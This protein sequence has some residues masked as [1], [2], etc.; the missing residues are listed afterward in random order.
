[1]SKKITDQRAYIGNMYSGYRTVKDGGVFKFDGIKY[2][3]VELRDLVGERVYVVFNGHSHFTS[4]QILVFP[5][6]SINRES[7][8]EINH[9]YITQ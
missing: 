2:S 4:Y 8:C 9:Q 6:H 5:D 3:H 7:I 1:M